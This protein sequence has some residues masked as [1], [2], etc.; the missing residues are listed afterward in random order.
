MELNHD[1]SLSGFG[2]GRKRQLLGYDAKV[3]GGPAEAPVEYWLVRNSWGSYWGDW[4]HMRIRAHKSNNG[5]ERT[6]WYALTSGD[7][8]GDKD[9][10]EKNKEGNVKLQRRQ[11][12]NVNERFHVVA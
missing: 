9:S 1:I 10:G 2:V 7:V 11:V 3:D 8:S 5:V 4:G 6:C 12:Q